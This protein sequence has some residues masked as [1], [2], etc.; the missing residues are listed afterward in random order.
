MSRAAKVA[1]IDVIPLLAAAV[2]K[3]RSE[4]QSALDDLE[5]ELRRALDWI[6]HER[7]DYWAQELRRAGEVLIQARLKLQQAMVDSPRGRPRA[8]LHRREAGRGAGPTPRRH[9][10]AESRG[11]PPLGRRDRPRR[12]RLPPRPHPIRHLARRRPFAGG[13]RP[14]PDERV[15]CDLYFPGGAEPTVAVRAAAR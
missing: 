9:R 13:R 2:Q 6:H 15:A 8:V 14:G 7:K 12:R 5:T 3:F 10:R 1:S 11:C 4:G